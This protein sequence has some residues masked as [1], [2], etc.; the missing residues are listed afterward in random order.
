M[1]RNVK[2]GQGITGLDE[3]RRRLTMTCGMWSLAPPAF[4]LTIA[5]NS[6]PRKRRRLPDEARRAKAAGSDPMKCVY[7]P[8]SI[9][10]PAQPNVGLTDDPCAL[11]RIEAVTTQ[12]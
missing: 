2:S 5:T 7:L 10:N 9:K 4:A 12:R 3:F 6:R 11:P 8:E 1:Q